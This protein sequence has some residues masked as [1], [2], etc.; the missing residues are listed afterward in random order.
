MPNCLKD[1]KAD[2]RRLGIEAG[3]DFAECCAMTA[4]YADYGVSYGMMKG[5]EVARASG[6][7]IVWRFIGKNDAPLDSWIQIPDIKITQELIDEFSK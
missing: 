3:L 2:E 1:S 5:I 6:R 4:V 7:P